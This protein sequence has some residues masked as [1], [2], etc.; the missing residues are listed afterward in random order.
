MTTNLRRVV[1]GRRRWLAGGVVL[2]WVACLW[3][4]GASRRAPQAPVAGDPSAVPEAFVP[5]HPAKAHIPMESSL[6]ERRAAALAAAS[7]RTLAHA[8]LIKNI[9]VDK[10]RVCPGDDFAVSVETKPENAG[11]DLPIAELNTNVDG[12]FGDQVV[13]HAGEPGTRELLA[14]AGNGIDKVDQRPFQ[15]EVLSADAPE[16]ASARIATLN[17][18]YA[19]PD[20]DSIHAKVAAVHGL[21]PPLYYEWSFGDGATASG[22]HDQVSHSYALRDQNRGIS[23]FIVQVTVTDKNGRQATG[24]D[25]IHFTNG[26]HLARA[27]GNRLTKTVYEPFPKLVPGGYRV[28]VTFRNLES[29]PVRYDQLTLTQ[30][31]CVAGHEDRVDIVPASAISAP[32]T[33]EANATKQAAITVPQSL[34]AA[35]TCVVELDLSG[36]SIPAKIGKPMENSPIAFR[37]VSTKLTLEL[38]AAP[39]KEQGGAEELASKHVDDPGLEAKLMAATKILGTNRVTPEQLAQLERDG[40]LP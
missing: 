31:S 17:V 1:N 5:V 21:E 8:D 16:C 37:A 10:R 27:F 35:D 38:H 6:E 39:S 13:L 32:Q 18:D 30:K 33:I 11:S 22:A 26:H 19:L 29:D 24:R 7:G 15:V 23:S 25:S 9:E 3:A 28:D 20:Q 14:V 34:V 40:L 2:I 4:Y 12:K 36:D